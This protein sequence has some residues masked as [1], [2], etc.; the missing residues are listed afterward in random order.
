VIMLTKRDSER[1]KGLERQMKA[2]RIIP[3]AGIL[4][5]ETPNG[6]VLS[7]NNNVVESVNHPFR[8]TL[9]GSTFVVNFGTVNN[10]EPRIDGIPISGDES[11]NQPEMDLPPEKGTGNYYIILEITTDKDHYID[12]RNGVQ[13]KVIKAN[14][15][16]TER[17]AKDDTTIIRTAIAFLKFYEGAM[18]FS[19]VLFFNVQYR[20]FLRE[21]GLYQ[22][23]VYAV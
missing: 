6:I 18:T 21:D 5:T 13:I 20:G 4:S 23:F 1:L 14:E 10:I 16:K 15:L 12:N 3:G 17:D 9:L 19:Q 2:S 8:V 7:V 11:G 22:H